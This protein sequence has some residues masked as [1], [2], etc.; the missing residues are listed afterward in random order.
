MTADPPTPSLIR[1]AVLDNLVARFRDAGLDTPLA[2]ARLLLSHALAIDRLALVTGSQELVAKLDHRRIEELARRRLARE[3]V[4]R[5]IGQRWFYGRPFHVTPVTLDPRPDTETIVEAAKSLFAER[6][7][8]PCRIL[9]VGT[10]TGCILLTLL[11]EFPQAKGLGTDI[12]PDAL[13]VARRNAVDLDLADRATFEAGADFA[14]ATGQFDLI[15]SNPP[16]IPSADIAGLDPEVRDFDPRSALDG[17]PDGLSIYRRLAAQYCDYLS[18]GWLILEVGH[19]QAA[20]VAGLFRAAA[21]GQSPPDVRT[22]HDLGGIAR[23][24]A[25]SPRLVATR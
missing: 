4:S 16:Y 13:D 20:A 12:S 1:Q 11:A 22:F 18:D 2:D 23:C 14:P 3:P 17:G 21:V 5:I 24:V 9:D 15:V 10:G 8:T 7:N 6:G 19:D 25:I